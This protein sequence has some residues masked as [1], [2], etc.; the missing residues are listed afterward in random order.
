MFHETS[1]DYFTSQSM[2]LALISRAGI[3]FII[4][5]KERVP[6]HYRSVSG[7]TGNRPMAWTSG[8]FQKVMGYQ[9][10]LPPPEAPQLGTGHEENAPALEPADS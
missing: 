5:G 2:A 8:L 7:R 6:V 4:A 3:E 9:P 10:F 1:T